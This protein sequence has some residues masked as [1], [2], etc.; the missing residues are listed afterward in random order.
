MTNQIAEKYAKHIPEALHTTVIEDIEQ[1][2]VRMSKG[3]V[4]VTDGAGESFWYYRGKKIYK[5][6]HNPCPWKIAGAPYSN[7]ASLAKIKAYIDS[8]LDA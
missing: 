2:S 4:K 6:E 3:C 5:Q 1:G 8:Q 7:C